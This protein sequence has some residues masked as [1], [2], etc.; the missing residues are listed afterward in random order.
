MKK[1]VL[2]IRLFP[3]ATALHAQKP[4]VASMVNAGSYAVAGL[5]N[6]AVAQGSLVILFG[7]NMGPATLQGAPSF[8]LQTTLAGTSISI[9]VNATT[10]QGIMIYSM[11]GQVAAVLPSR[12]PVGTGTLTVALQQPDQRPARYRCG[13]EQ[14]RRLYAESERKRHRGDPGWQRTGDHAATSGGSQSD[15]GDLGNR[16]GSNTGR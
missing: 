4:M 8:P 6:A 10:T 9:T 1:S 16:S 3:L 12:T 5:P 7:T 14:L 2:V 11:A 15:H 13:S